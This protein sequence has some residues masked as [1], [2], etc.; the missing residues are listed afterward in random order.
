MV[1]SPFI[2][3]RTQPRSYILDIMTSPHTPTPAPPVLSDDIRALQKIVEKKDMELK[4]M[5]EEV[6]TLKHART[7]IEELLQQTESEMSILSSKELFLEREVLQLNTVRK[8]QEFTLFEASRGLTEC[9]AQL[10]TLGMASSSA[11]VTSDVNIASVRPIHAV[12]TDFRQMISEIKSVVAAC[13]EA[14][15]EAESKVATENA[16]YTKSLTG[17]QSEL[18]KKDAVILSLNN[19]V[20]NVENELKEKSVNEQ[21]LTNLN[22][23]LEE[24]LGS[25]LSAASTS[26]KEL[27]SRGL[28]FESKMDDMKRSLGEKDERISDL[29]DLCRQMPKIKKEADDTKQ[30]Y[31]TQLEL[32]T[33]DLVKMSQEHENLKLKL[34]DAAENHAATVHHLESKL[35]HRREKSEELTEQMRELTV[36]HS[37]EL[38]EL[39]SKCQIVEKD[40]HKKSDQVLGLQTL[41]SRLDADHSAFRVAAQ[42]TI[43]QL[44]NNLI[45]SHKE[46]TER[47]VQLQTQCEELCDAAAKATS[48]SDQLE[49]VLVKK[50]TDL[51]HARAEISALQFQMRCSESLEVEKANKQAEKVKSDYDARIA[52]MSDQNTILLRESQSLSSEVEL[53]NR[54]QKHNA[55]DYSLTLQ[56]ICNS[57]SGKS[58]AIHDL[59]R[60]LHAK[61]CECIEVVRQAT[62]A[63]HTNRALIEEL[64]CELKSKDEKCVVLS[65]EVSCLSQSLNDV[66]VDLNKLS[67]DYSEKEAQCL[68]LTNDICRIRDE[69]SLE[70]D[71]ANAESAHAYASI[72]YMEKKLKSSE[73]HFLLVDKELSRVHEI[74]LSA[75]PLYFSCAESQSNVSPPAQISLW[76]ECLLK[77]ISEISESNESLRTQLTLLEQQLGVSQKTVNAKDEV[78]Y[79]NETKLKETYALLGESREKCQKLS[80]A[81]TK[82][83]LL[84]S[85]SREVAHNSI[86]DLQRQQT[87]ELQKSNMRYEEAKDMSGAALACLNGTLRNLHGIISNSGISVPEPAPNQP[88]TI[89]T[90]QEYSE[91]LISTIRSHYAQISNLTHEAQELLLSNDAFAS[92]IN[93]LV[94]ELETVKVTLRDESSKISQQSEVEEELRHKIQ[95]QEKAFE[96]VQNLFHE[97]KCADRSAIDSH[98]RYTENL[99]RDYFDLSRMHDAEN[100]KIGNELSECLLEN[101]VLAE[102]IK[103]V[104]AEAARRSTDY[105]ERIKSVAQEKVVLEMEMRK[106]GEMFA[107]LYKELTARS[108]ELHPDFQCSESMISFTRD[109]LNRGEEIHEIVVSLKSAKQGAEDSL[110]VALQDLDFK[111]GIERSLSSEV[112][113]CEVSLVEKGVLLDKLEVDRT[114]L[115]KENSVLKDD[116]RAESSSKR[117][118]E[119]ENIELCRDN[120]ELKLSLNSKI[121]DLSSQLGVFREKN[122]LM[123][124]QVS[125]IWY[126]CQKIFT[127]SNLEQLETSGFEEKFQATIEILG[128]LGSRMKTLTESEH[129]LQLKVNDQKLIEAG[130]SSENEQLSVALSDKADLLSRTLEEVSQL[131]N[132]ISRSSA[133][134]DEVTGQHQDKIQSFDESTK[135]NELLIQRQKDETEEIIAR[136]ESL[137]TK[138]NNQIKLFENLMTTKDDELNKLSVAMKDREAQH[139]KGMSDVK[140]DLH[141]VQT[142]LERSQKLLLESNNSLQE[143][144]KLTGDLRRAVDELENACVL[145]TNKVESLEKSMSSKLSEELEKSRLEYCARLEQVQQEKEEAETRLRKLTAEN[146]LQ[147]QCHVEEVQVLTNKLDGN[148]NKLDSV[149]VNIRSYLQDYLPH[150]KFE[151]LIDQTHDRTPKK[152][153]SVFMDIEAYFQKMKEHQ[154]SEL[155]SLRSSI[156]DD[157]AKTVTKIVADHKNNLESVVSGWS[158][159]VET[160]TI[161]LK[162]SEAE[163]QELRHEMDSVCSKSQQEK[164]DFEK[165]IGHLQEKLE[166]VSNA[167]EALETCKS[168]KV[169]EIKSEKAEATRL[170]EVLEETSNE[171]QIL[172][173]AKKKLEERVEVLQNSILALESR[174]EAINKDLLSKTEEHNAVISDMHSKLSQATLARDQALFECGKLRESVSSLKTSNEGILQDFEALKVLSEE[175]TKAADERLDSVTKEKYELR[176]L[177]E[178]KGRDISNMQ[179]NLEQKELTLRTTELSKQS[180]ETALSELKGELERC[181][182]RY[183]L[184]MEEMESKLSE[185][186][187]KLDKMSEKFVLSQAELKKS[188]NYGHETSAEVKRLEEMVRN[189]KE[190]ILPPLKAQNEKLKDDILRSNATIR[191]QTVEI[192]NLKVMDSGS[193]EITGLRKEL[194]NLQSV[195]SNMIEKQKELMSEIASLQEIC[196]TSD[197]AAGMYQKLSK[198][199]AKCMHKLRR[200]KQFDELERKS[201]LLN[202]GEAGVNDENKIPAT[203]VRGKR[204]AVSLAP[205]DLVAPMPKKLRHGEQEDVDGNKRRGPMQN[206]TGSYVNL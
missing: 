24:K 6:E 130:L 73:E 38:N 124:D 133:L 95:Q 129:N 182:E 172:K 3:P 205:Q 51:S 142:D 134:L 15:A 178:C 195:R 117:T 16:S 181:N 31:V 114:N 69:F 116:L 59:E 40:L 84:V 171:T 70:L 198:K 60:K 143:E 32:Q 113:K 108:L 30:A 156:N 157:H 28:E 111:R 196:R 200:Y 185:M 52:S 115:L 2:F 170:R 131:T 81:F 94:A 85:Q 10:S 127:G 33:R 188:E 199:H 50:D 161:Q 80:D 49:S 26:E 163:L 9:I 180:A 11:P 168:Q 66:K 137:S 61:K 36:K 193:K 72:G 13:R 167:V 201:G 78:I 123:E 146:Q 126:A 90:L 125:S 140:G 71:T 158:E 135:K 37:K 160:L 53:L 88:I 7:Q 151:G 83:N 89:P 149:A 64:Q 174:I 118:V 162:K 19:R 54:Y 138:L 98:L 87:L 164:Q 191:R 82:C 109:I 169:E 47:I 203:S 93:S 204:R 5:S 99:E 139:E 55:R 202:K 206:I 62:L 96:E 97:A 17:L 187:R 42:D 34:H 132:E 119:Q 153:R 110:K 63:D 197:K 4:S 65:G 194:E 77:L 44:E 57:L 75:H 159:R 8:Q 176:A 25:A 46:A 152:G 22:A 20:L 14:K 147:R 76:S 166:Q 190:E 155:S 165:T 23:D 67:A 27:Q 101:G 48:R 173:T 12:L 144:R 35:E 136:T 1:S 120:E 68:S 122:S 92:E 112:K 29:N 107:L 39:L 128:Q 79:V 21:L 102:K 18:L 141:K 43:L 184:V 121:S 86:L 100:Q 177:I 56:S 105:D 148:E 103:L 179:N 91:T 154:Q 41:I 106:V 175:Q 45:S 104:V 192:A 186:T 145:Q 58:Q 150:D 189:F 183:E 74:L